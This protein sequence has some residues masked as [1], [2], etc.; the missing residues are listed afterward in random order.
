MDFRESISLS[1]CE[2]SEPHIHSL[3]PLGCFLNKKGLGRK[4][5]IES[6]GVWDS[7]VQVQTVTPKSLGLETGVKLSIEHVSRELY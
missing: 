7:L 4:N 6:R 1:S 5:H 2:D 3:C